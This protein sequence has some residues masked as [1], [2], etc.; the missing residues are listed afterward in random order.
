MAKKTK[1][2]KKKLR[3]KRVYL[4][5]TTSFLLLTIITI[6]L[7][8]ILSAFQMQGVYGQIDLNTSSIDQTLV[9]V[10]NLLSFNELKV[11]ISNSITNFLSFGPLGTLLISLVGISIAEAT[12][13]LEVLTRRKIKKIPKEYLTF[14]IIFLSVISSIINDVGYSILIPI[15]GLLYFMNDRNPI[16]G[17]VTSFCGVSF[18]YGVTIF[19]GSQDVTLINYT[20]AATSII[21]KNMHISLSSNL[22]FI[23]VAT[24][25][26]SI[27]GTL[28]IE[29]IIAKQIG[30]YKRE[31]LDSKTEK[32][33]VINLEE[34]EQ[35]EIEKDLREKKGLKI[36]H[37]V[38]IILLLLTIYSL[39]PN[40]P[41]SGFLLDNTKQT[42]VE[43]L[44]GEN[45]YFQNSFTLIISMFL[46]IISLAY[47]KGAGTL[48]NDKELIEK[49]STRFENIGSI[50]LLFFIFS[51]FISVFKETNIGTVITIWLSNLLNQMTLTGIPL[52]IIST[53]FVAISS[54]FL[55]SLPT[56]W[57]IYSSIIVPM[58]MQANLSPEFGQIV[59]RVGDSMTKGITPF[60]AAFAI[61]IG[62]LNIYNLN[63][64][65]PYTI[66]RA[67]NL[68]KPYFLI[69]SL[70]WLLLLIGWYLVGLPIGPNV[71]PTL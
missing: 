66:T 25:I 13:F 24:I 39:I 56:K 33:K 69:I 58:Y 4:H 32:Y 63:K 53:L 21:D 37:I 51:Q 3:L 18:G 71:Y 46:I 28:V 43:K 61:Y 6:F 22:I 1:I 60:L 54:L 70:T 10:K 11:I 49:A 31:E 20:R 65:K 16:L 47:A 35:K 40:L 5:P 44:F 55:T 9:T 36:A 34:E 8:A 30:H 41:A 57:S 19:T 26:I 7:S 50:I 42:Y 45:A 12:G 27:V 48:K 15:A 38:G 62:Y 2:K 68:I 29:K 14:I 17:I 52:I 64:E 67:I 59:V 23:I